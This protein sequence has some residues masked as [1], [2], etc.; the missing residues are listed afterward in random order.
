MATP[1]LTVLMPVYNAAAFVKEA[2]ESILAQTFSNFEFIIIDDGSTD[3]TVAIVTAYTDSRIRFFK[4]TENKGISATLNRGIKLAEGSFIARMDAD[5]ISLPN[6]LQTQVD[7]LLNHPDV[8]MVACWAQVVNQIGKPT[9]VDLFE[10][11]FYYYNITF[12]CWIYH[13]TV[14]YKKEAVQKLG[15]YTVPYAEDYELFW[16]FYRLG[17]VA[18]L[19]EVLLHYRETNQSLHQVL[20]KDEYTLAEQGQVRRNI[21]FYTGSRFFVS[22]IELE[23]LRHHFTPMLERGSVVALL[24]LL[25]K[26]DTIT[27]AILKTENENRNSEDIKKAAYYK[28]KYIIDHFKKHWG[29]PKATLLLLGTSSPQTLLF[30]A[31]TYISKKFNK[32]GFQ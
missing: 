3:N 15:G 26:L 10:P 7:Y 13:P 14:V 9:R 25:R 32:I 21:S 8:N 2:I 19:P 28:R 11:Q 5:D 4:N 6:R 22:N 24:V 29:K 17:K 23:C 20:K 1:L 30:K 31:K 12:I 27:A 16:H 18:V